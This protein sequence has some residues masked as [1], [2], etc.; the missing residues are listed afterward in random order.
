ML[1]RMARAAG[2]EFTSVSCGLG[3][4]PTAREVH[5]AKRVV[6]LGSTGNT[7]TEQ[8]DGP[9]TN[10]S[11]HRSAL[12]ALVPGVPGKAPGLSGYTVIVGEK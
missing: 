12:L 7:E 4:C 5:A 3:R 6:R 1:C 8:S 11:N 9:R 2:P 10:Q